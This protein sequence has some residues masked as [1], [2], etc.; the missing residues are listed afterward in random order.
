MNNQSERL[1]RVIGLLSDEKI[2]LAE[3]QLNSKGSVIDNDTSKA[4]IVPETKSQ[5]IKRA[6]GFS[7][8]F[9]G[10][11]AALVLLVVGTL[12]MFH[13][14]APENQFTPSIPSPTTDFEKFLANLSLNGWLDYTIHDKSTYIAGGLTVEKWY[15][16][17]IG[18]EKDENVISV[19]EYPTSQQ[20]EDSAWG[21]L[22]GHHMPH[23]QGILDMH[24]IHPPNW[25]KMNTLIILYSG[26]NSEIV[27]FLD[28][29]YDR[30]TYTD[31]HPTESHN[32]TATVTEIEVDGDYNTLLVN[33]P[34]LS[35][36]FVGGLVIVPLD[37]VDRLSASGEKIRH[38]FQVGDIVRVYYDGIVN[39]SDPLQLGEVFEI[40]LLE[41]VSDISLPTTLEAL[42]RLHE[43]INNMQEGEGMSAT[44]MI[45]MGVSQKVLDTL[46]IP[47]E[48]LVDSQENEL[49]PIYL[50]L[51]AGADEEFDRVFQE[52]FADVE[53]ATR[54]DAIL[55][56]NE[57][58]GNA[59]IEKYLKS[60]HEVI[61]FDSTGHNI[62]III[63]ATAQEI[64]DFAENDEVIAI[65]FYDVNTIPSP[66][67][68][69]G[70]LWD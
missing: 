14:L 4:I 20:V 45:E 58:I 17:Y 12:A 22:T 30:L 28:R 29:N 7:V 25:F 65:A 24:W 2:A 6:K 40:R 10:M 34:Y 21:I 54:R 44:E 38:A 64:L 11:A 16:V 62:A 49:I 68:P 67:G 41:S 61:Y 66:S 23:L 8:Q 13:F 19:F 37:G 55:Q 31:T 51:P 50:L 9:A 59:F 5:P 46:F 47:Y 33:A 43:K 48:I 26:D 3:K 39:D 36:N 63:E 35:S 53:G 57:V 15:W 1:Y 70:V 42:A 60:S 27:D 56:V 18:D 69:Q 32:F 52:N